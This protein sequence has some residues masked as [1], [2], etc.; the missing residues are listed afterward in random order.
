MR[1]YKEFK[2]RYNEKVS[3]NTRNK[4]KIDIILPIFT[5]KPINIIKIIIFINI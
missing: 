1:R 2:M 3:G 5:M 4:V